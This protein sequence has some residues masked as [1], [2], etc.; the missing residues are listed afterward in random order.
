MATSGGDKGT[1][2]HAVDEEAP[3]LNITSSPPVLTTSCTVPSPAAPEPTPA[4]SRGSAAGKRKRQADDRVGVPLRAYH[5]RQRVVKPSL[6]MPAQQHQEQQKVHGAKRSTP[7]AKRTTNFR[8]KRDDIG[9]YRQF[10]MAFEDYVR[11]LEKSVPRIP[12]IDQNQ[13]LSAWFKGMDGDFQDEIVAFL[14]SQESKRL[15]PVGDDVYKLDFNWAEFKPIL[16]SLG[17][18]SKAG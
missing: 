15:I 8:R 14:T 4:L 16:V 2:A 18:L 12:A 1:V 3:T 5:L 9:Q 6:T 11:I 13:L 10:G 7:L 17:M